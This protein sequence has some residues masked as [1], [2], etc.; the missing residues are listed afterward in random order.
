MRRFSLASVN[1]VTLVVGSSSLRDRVTL[2]LETSFNHVNDLTRP[3][4][5]CMKSGMR[6]NGFYFMAAMSSKNVL[7]S[8]LLRGYDYYYFS[9]C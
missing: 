9:D 7:L 3:P 1:K 6:T 4:E 2:G 8:L 5:L